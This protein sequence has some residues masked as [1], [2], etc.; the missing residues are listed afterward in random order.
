VHRGGG[1]GLKEKYGSVNFRQSSL[2]R[3]SL[4]N[5]I[6]EDYQG[7]GYDLSLRQLYYQLVAGGHI[8]NSEKSYKNTGNLLNDGRMAGLIDWDVITD[9]TRT[10]YNRQ[11]DEH[12]PADINIFG[13]VN[14]EIDGCFSS[15]KWAGQPFYLEAWVEK[16]ALS[17]IISSA[18]R[19]HD[20]AYFAC[21][22]YTSLTAL[23]EAAERLK[24]KHESGR[25]CV[26]IYLGDHDPS[27]IDMTRDI[28]ER[29]EKFGAVVDVQRIALNMEQI[30]RFNPPPNPAK[31]TDTRA[32]GYIEKY[33]AESW[34]LDALRPQVLH[35]LIVEKISEYFDPEINGAN[36]R[37]MENYKA[38]QREKYQPV[39][40]AIGE[41]I[42]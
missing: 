21:K 26:L 25:D 11:W 14:R 37:E 4:I 13:A 10:L 40:D 17:E 20:V 27:G 19:D 30:E 6:I 31:E 9:R 36:V 42:A 22:G 3:I 38:K 24:K 1:A 41:Q 35:D 33:G 7:Q 23:Y 16:E 12:G 39:L 5:G 29:L 15:S 28:R 18:A 8:E 32:Q 34:E 2:D